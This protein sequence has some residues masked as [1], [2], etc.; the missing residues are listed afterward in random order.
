MFGSGGCPMMSSDVELSLKSKVFSELA[1]VEF[2]RKEKEN[3][4]NVRLAYAIGLRLRLI[5]Q[6]E[7]SVDYY[8]ASKSMFSR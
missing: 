3:L 7:T 5:R 8:H 2:E 1:I 4:K 6:L